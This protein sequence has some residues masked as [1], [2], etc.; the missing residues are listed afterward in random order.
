M[1]SETVKRMVESALTDA[2]KD[3]LVGAMRSAYNNVCIR[4]YNP[5]EGWDSMAFGFVV[6][7]FI[8]HEIKQI[9]TDKSLGIEV[10]P[11]R[12]AFRM[13]IGGL[14]F[15]TYALGHHA[16]SDIEQTFPNNHCASGQ[17]A[18]ANVQLCFQLGEAAYVP[19]HFI[20][21]H[22]GCPESGLEQVWVSEPLDTKNGAVTEWGFRE[23]IWRWDQAGGM[24]ATTPLL[25]GPT[26]LRPVSIT[27]K[28]PAAEAE[29]KPSA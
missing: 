23:E 9:V 19:R 27:L 13:R 22:L 29:R 15:G 8:E 10:E 12:Q 3:A 18:A 28:R 25:P 20:L 21:G 14:T 11:H 2:R 6:W 1:N 26:R 5:D 17:L 16:V 24:P 7:K 4:H